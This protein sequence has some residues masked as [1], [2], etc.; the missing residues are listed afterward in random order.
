VIPRSRC[1]QLVSVRVQYYVEIARPAEALNQS[2][3]VAPG[4]IFERRAT[5]TYMNGRANS[6]ILLCIV[7]SVCLLLTCLSV[8]DLYVQDGAHLAGFLSARILVGE[9]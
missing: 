5:R 8:F 9:K 7:L 3:Y 4:P 6:Y 1:L 2:S